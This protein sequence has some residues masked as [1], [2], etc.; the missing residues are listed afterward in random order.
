MHIAALPTRE[1]A[2]MTDLLRVTTLLSGGW[3]AGGGVVTHHFIAG[4]TTGAQATSA[5]FNF[6]NYNP[7]I[8]VSGTKFSV[9]AEVEQIDDATGDLLGVLSGTASSVTASGAGEGGPPATQGLIR[10]RTG[11]VEDSR[12]IRGRTFLPAVPVSQIDDGRPIAGYISAATTM[13][14]LLVS[15][16]STTL[17][18]WRRPRP[19]RPQVGVKGDR[20]Y[21]PQQLERAGSSAAVVTYSLWDSFAV[22]R[23][24]RD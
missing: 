16:A 6:W 12:E 5:V 10:W 22:L 21:L 2:T 14:G 15:D 13:A 1:R 8:F 9:Q 20:W 11:V 24:R 4:S 17:A 19:F 7:G 23:S 3:V 18:V